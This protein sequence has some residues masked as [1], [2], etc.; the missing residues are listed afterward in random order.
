VELTVTKLVRG[1]V[2][3]LGAFG[4]NWKNYE[5]AMELTIN[6]EVLVEPLVTHRYPIDE[7]QSAFEKAKA[8]E[9]CKVQLVM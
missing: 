1:E 3:L 8:K 6:H 7:A 2:A 9:G 4:S 5:E